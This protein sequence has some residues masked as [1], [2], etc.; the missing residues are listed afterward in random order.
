MKI[1]KFLPLLLVMLLA[2]STTSMATLNSAN[3]IDK[4]ANDALKTFYNEVKGSKKYLEHAKAYLV[5]PDIKEAGFFVG[6]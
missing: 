4:D 2:F 1:L 6:W 5:F 3:E